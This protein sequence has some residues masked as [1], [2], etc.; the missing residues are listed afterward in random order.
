MKNGFSFVTL[1]SGIVASAL[2][3]SPSA[4]ASSQESNIQQATQWY[5]SITVYNSTTHNRFVLS[6]CSWMPSRK[7]ANKMARRMHK[8]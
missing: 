7:I 2:T 6:K 5:C 4:V 3:L 1:L 8:H